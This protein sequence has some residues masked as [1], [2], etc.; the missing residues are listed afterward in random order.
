MLMKAEVA[1]LF[2]RR[3]DS[4]DKPMYFATVIDRTGQV[5]SIMVPADRMLVWDIKPCI[6]LE[7]LSFVEL[8]LAPFVSKAGK[9]G[10]MVAED[11]G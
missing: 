11:V 10:F 1:V 5:S 3:S 2:V 6:E 9:Q 4:Q 8:P 7:D